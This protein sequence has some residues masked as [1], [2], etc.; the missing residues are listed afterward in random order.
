MSNRYAEALAEMADTQMPEG[1]RVRAYDNW[2]GD[3]FWEHDGGGR[4][5][6]NLYQVNRCQVDNRRNPTE[7]DRERLVQLIFDDA[8]KQAS[9]PRYTNEAHYKAVA[10]RDAMELHWTAEAGYLA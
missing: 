3:V 7:A 6:I 1:V 5:L 2:P 10:A 4:G 8:R 9:D